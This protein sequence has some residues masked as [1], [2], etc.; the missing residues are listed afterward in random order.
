MLPSPNALIAELQRDPRFKATCPVCR[1]NFRLSDAVL[2]AVGDQ[3]P[4]AALDALQAMRER[5]KERRRE[6]AS[7]RDLMTKTAQRTAEAVNLGKIVEKIVPSFATFSY[8]P[9]DCRALFEPIDYLVFS[10]LAKQN[11]VEALFFVD[12]KSGNA[13]LSSSQRSI[14]QAVEKRGGALRNHAEARLMAASI[15]EIFGALGQLMA[16]CPCCGELFY[17][18]EAHPY[19]EG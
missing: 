11:H 8:E 4:K 18:S 15:G 1:Q 9:G 16:V 13:R 2:F 3:P 5:I 7:N 12:V 19:Y 14:K 17:V 6:L 10:G